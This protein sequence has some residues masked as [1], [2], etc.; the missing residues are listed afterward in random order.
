MMVVVKEWFMRAITRVKLILGFA[1]GFAMTVAGL[2]PQAVASEGPSQVI[3][4]ARTEVT[5]PVE[6][7]QV[8]QAKC[9]QLTVGGG[10][11]LRE[12]C[13]R[14]REILPVMS[15]EPRATVWAD[16]ME[17]FLRKWIESLGPDGFT[18]RN[19]ECRL[20]WCV[21][22]SGSTVGAGDRRGH[23]IVLE[24][25]EA[26]KSK[27]FQVENL[28]ARDPDDANAWDVIVFFKR[29]CRSPN[30]IFDGSSHLVSDFY[31]LGQK[32]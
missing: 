30:E 4:P 8:Q 15:A 16:A 26:G 12:Q 7:P 28:F 11:P 31:T 2:F 18:F 5:S 13:L 22:E 14:V 6:L 9:K 3:T 10:G 23:D 29:Y 21:V 27:I 19:V 17:S 24:S 20:S 25:A 32:C 1:F